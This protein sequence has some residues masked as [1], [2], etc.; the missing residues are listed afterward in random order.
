T[1]E[2]VLSFTRGP[3]ARV[4]AIETLNDKV[5]FTTYGQGILFEYDPSREYN[6]GN[7]PRQVFRLYED[8]HQERI[9]ALETVDD[10]TIA[11]GT[12]GGRGIDTG[13]LFL[14]NDETQ[15]KTDLGEPL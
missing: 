4:D 14:Y 2:E 9:Y 8:Y 12:I 11:L 10:H 15:E 7:N 13:Q 6:Y 3:S 5:Y 1:A